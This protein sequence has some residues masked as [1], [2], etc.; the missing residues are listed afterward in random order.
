MNWG[1]KL[2]LVFAAFGGMISYMVYR[3]MQT[4]VDLVNK[5]YYRD[6]LVYQEVIDGS[7]KANALSGKLK[8][9]QEAGIISLQL[10]EEMKNTGTGLKG[11]IFFYCPSDV[12]KDRH[13]ILQPDSAA[14]Q[15]ITTGDKALLPGHYTVKVQWENK[16]IRY[17][18]EQPFLVQ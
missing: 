14:R 3:C 2:L 18:T 1:N 15:E 6:E 16:G 13:I 5:E 11:N 4:P 8:L 12:T 9:R 7:K 17:F 10:P